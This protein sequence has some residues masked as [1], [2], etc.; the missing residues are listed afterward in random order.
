MT[1]F[2]RD[3]MLKM[4]YEAY[5]ASSTDESGSESG[6]PGG[7]GGE[8]KEDHSLTKNSDRVAK[9]R[10]LLVG[11]GSGDIVSGGGGEEE[12]EVMEITW[13][14]GLREGVEEMVRRRRR[15]GEGEGETTWEHYLRE[16]NRKTKRTKTETKVCKYECVCVCECVYISRVPMTMVTM[17]MVDSLR[18]ASG[19]TILSS[20]RMLP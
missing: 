1:R 12:E 9:Y 14:P 18:T 15:E 10:S 2:S 16:K 7:V 6:T 8:P 5:L 13:E 11:S 17:A 4:D 3:D 20:K 19:L